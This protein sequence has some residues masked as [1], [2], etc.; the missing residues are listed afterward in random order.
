MTIRLAPEPTAQVSV[1]AATERFGRAIERS[2]GADFPFYNAIPA[3]VATWKWLLVILSGIVGFLALVL[4]PVDDQLLLLVP[5]VFFT[6]IQLITF[7]LLVEPHWRAI[8]RPVRA[9]DVGAIVVFWL[10]NLVVSSILGLVVR[11]LFGA[12]GDAAIGGIAD[13]SLIEKGA[14][15]V[16]SGI[17][18]LGE[19]LFTI[20]PLLALLTWFHRAGMRR[21]TALLLAWTIT[22]VWFGLAHLP[23]YGWN[24]IQVLVVIGVA[25]LILSLAFIRTKNVWV[26]TGAHVL[27]DW[28]SF[29]LV[30]FLG[31]SAAPAL[32]SL[33]GM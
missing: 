31:A 1:P 18:I 8:F 9:A 21:S 15:F 20:L 28:F 13:L 25:R 16:G 4:C 27:H 6:A 33:I 7:A 10:M 26:S 19:E 30:M 17:Q 2:D 29:A 22:A 3:D 12:N 23:A 11:A 14:F 32:L 24:V 5:R